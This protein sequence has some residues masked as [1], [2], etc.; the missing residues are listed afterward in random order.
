M[1]GPRYARHT[2]T[3]HPLTRIDYVLLLVLAGLIIAVGVGLLFLRRDGVLG[4]GRETPAFSFDLVDVRQVP[5]ER[6]APQ[7][8]LDRDATLVHELLDRLYAGGFVDPEQWEDGR[9][10]S[11]FDAFSGDAAKSASTDLEDLTLG[12]LATRL[13]FV[14]PVR[15][16]LRVSFL[17]DPMGELYAAVAQTRFRAR[18]ELGTGGLVR[19]VHGGTYFLRPL[20]GAWMVVGY[21]V[22]GA[23]D[24]LPPG[25]QPS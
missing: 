12:D 4:G 7:G 22:K 15:G 6:T 2:R 20:R 9:F 21:N 18:G 19:I 13:D 3:K 14:D 24:S 17:V 23:S 16:R 10:T 8:E 25:F 1:P 11:L 5:I